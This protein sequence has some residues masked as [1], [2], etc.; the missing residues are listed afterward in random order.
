[1]ELV[2]PT[3]LEAMAV[4][5]IM[6][7]LAAIVSIY[8]IMVLFTLVR[9]CLPFFLICGLMVTI[10]ANTHSTGVWLIVFL[11]M[12]VFAICYFNGTKDSGNGE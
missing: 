10:L 12:T 2:M 9:N 6:G 4:M 8:A 3:S 11:A 5:A 7:T 1:M